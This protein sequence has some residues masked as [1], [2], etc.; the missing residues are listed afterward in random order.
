MSTILWVVGKVVRHTEDGAVWEFE[1]VF[2]GPAAADAA[3]VSEFHFYGAAEL[4]RA[5]DVSAPWP[6]A[7]YP[8]CRAVT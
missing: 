8:R 3:C 2:S 1:G 4:D 6:G 5:V 7:R